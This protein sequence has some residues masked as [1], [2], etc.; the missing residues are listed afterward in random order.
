M[1]STS[2]KITFSKLLTCTGDCDGSKL[3]LWFGFGFTMLNVKP[4]FGNTNTDSLQSST[5]P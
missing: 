1:Y 2:G 5:F 3:F 4:L